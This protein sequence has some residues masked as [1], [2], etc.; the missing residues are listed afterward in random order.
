MAGIGTY[1]PIKLI[2][3]T[4]SLDANGDNVETLALIYKM[5]AE[6]KSLG[7]SR[8]LL[9]EQ[10]ALSDSKTFKIM[11]KDY[12]INADFKIQYFGQIYAIS[13]IERI[14]EKRF[15]WL[16]TAYNIFKQPALLP[17]PAESPGGGGGGGGTVTNWTGY[18][19]NQ[20]L[21]TFTLTG[22]SDDDNF[23]RLT[24]YKYPYD[25]TAYVNAY[26]EGFS[27]GPFVGNTQTLQYFTPGQA[28]LRW[29]RVLNRP[30][31]TVLT[32]SAEQVITITRLS[33]RGVF[34]YDRSTG[35]IMG[36]G[37]FPKEIFNVNGVSL[38]TATSEADYISK[39]NADT[40]NQACF[41]I[42]SATS[43]TNQE[44]L[45]DP[46]SPFQ[47]WGFSPIKFEVD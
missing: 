9:K 18:S 37:A 20:A 38:G 2:K 26:N 46:I 10:T 13:S 28:L 24:I 16:I 45:I 4:T 47:T 32:T 6:V 8:S 23:T 19:Y 15:N 5:W 3:Y 31:Y 41:N 42:V 35:R 43:N 30:P 27:I 34:V 29:E 7:G 39:M 36:K 33:R 14:D 12:P 17:D 11:F 40:A 44:F 21:G 25:G 22:G 1:K